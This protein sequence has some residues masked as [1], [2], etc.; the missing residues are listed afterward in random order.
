MGLY[1]NIKE[2]C[3]SQ[4]MSIR[5]LESLL[6]LSYGSVS[7]WND[8]EPSFTKI[9]KVADF[10]GVPYYTLLGVKDDMHDVWFTA[11]ET[12]LMIMI[13]HLNRAGQR[14]VRE[15]VNDIYERYKA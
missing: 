12:A 2:L 1:D 5:E 4:D 10:F 9:K 14:K 8:H 13:K 15:Y 3:K 7:K 6:G 11:D